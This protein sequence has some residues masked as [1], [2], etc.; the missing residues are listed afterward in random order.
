MTGGIRTAAL[1]LGVLGVLGG[2]LGLLFA[3]GQ[4]FTAAEGT[5]IGELFHLNT[6][7][8]IV[9]VVLGAVTLAGATLGRRVVVLAASAGWL[10]AALLT[11]L[12]SGGEPNLLGGTASTLAFFLGI[13]GGLGM[14][15]IAP[16]ET[17]ADGA[18]T[19][20]AAGDRTAGDRT[21]G[22]RAV[23]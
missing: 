20:G 9:S 14:L 17:R 12:Q 19:D 21:A 7:G 2:V 3:S 18:A 8:A 1:V 4:P 5:R 11:V 23:G 13:G 22:D 15:A 6:L 10:L 16:A